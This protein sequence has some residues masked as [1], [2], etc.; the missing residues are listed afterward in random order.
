MTSPISNIKQL[1]GRV[2][3]N[4]EGKLTPI[5]VDMVDYGCKYMANTFYKR[6][7]YYNEENWPIEYL[8]YS[9][10]KLNKIDRETTYKIIRGE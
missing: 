7:H 10:N 1:T 4:K 5:V 2:I 6:E 9:K 3:R 8:I